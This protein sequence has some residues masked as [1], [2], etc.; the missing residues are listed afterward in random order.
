ML[1][2]ALLSAGGA[3]AQTAEQPKTETPGQASP[4]PQVPAVAPASPASDAPRNVSVCDVPE[5]L[6]GSESPLPR[7]AK[8][9]KA[10][11]LNILVLGSRSSIIVGGTEKFS[12]PGQMLEAL[13]Q[14]LAPV[15]VNMT[16]EVQVKKTAE[17][18]EP[19]VP[20]ML[21]DNKP[22]LVIWQTGTVDAMRA[23]DPDDFRTALDDVTALMMA[24]SDVVLLNLQ[25]SPRTETMIAATTYLD[26]MRVVAQQHSVPLFDRFA[27]MRHWHEA[28]DFDLF[29]ASHGVELARKVHHCLGIALSRFITD[30]AQGKPGESGN[31]R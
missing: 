31:T 11:K 21:Q 25:Y 8:A 19:L 24:A 6:L 5:H 9:I 4:S 2:A 10:G 7:V 18:L 13:R 20:K 3:S 29:S 23:V 30:I 27:I 14:R 22:D 16:V 12:Y 28:G 17:E 1:L 26:N 15:E